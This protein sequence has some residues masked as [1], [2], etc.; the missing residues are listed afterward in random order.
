MPLFLLRLAN[1]LGEIYRYINLFMTTKTSGIITSEEPSHEDLP[2]KLRITNKTEEETLG[3]QEDDGRIVS[4]TEQT[5]K[6]LP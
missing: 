4:E 5:I 2:K 1:Y 3:K 6:S